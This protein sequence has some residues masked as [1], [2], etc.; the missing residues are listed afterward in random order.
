MSAWEPTMTPD[1]ALALV[2]DARRRVVV[3]TI[4]DGSGVT[5]RQALVRTVVEEETGRPIAHADTGRVQDVHISL[6]HNHLPKLS[7]YDV[8]RH[9]RDTGEVALS[10]NADALG[11]VLGTL[12]VSLDAIDDFCE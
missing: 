10:D 6:Y 1:T 4:L 12:T 3:D 5:T 9:D 2:S 8:I 7:R 11:E